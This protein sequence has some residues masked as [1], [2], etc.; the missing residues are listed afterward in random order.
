METFVGIVEVVK[1]VSVIVACLVAVYGFDAWRREFVGKRRM[2]LAEEVLALFYEAR[3]VLSEIRSLW[4]YEGEG[5]TR[6]SRDNESPEEKA[7]LDRAY[8]VVERFNKHR[9]TF[10]RIQAL[11]YRFMAQFG[12]EA[13]VPFIRLTEIVNQVFGAAHG[14]SLI[15]KTR[16]RFAHQDPRKPEVQEREQKWEDKHLSVFYEFADD[17]PLK[18]RIE[19]VV[20]EIERVCSNIINS[21]GTL[22]G[23]LNLPVKVRR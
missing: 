20:R 2:E 15:W 4:G 12:T 19:D 6:Q 8:I 21:R 14:L 16:L 13:G 3:D 10:N 22:F 23:V 17:D 1:G 7:A 18:P 5:S 9:D 11:R